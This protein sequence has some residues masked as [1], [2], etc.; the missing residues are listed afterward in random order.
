[1]PVTFDG[2]N[3]KIILPSIADYSIDLDLYSAWKEWVLLSDNA[4]YP[5][6]FDTTGGDP[7]SAVSRIAPYFFIRNDLGWRVQAPE[8]TGEINLDGNLFPRDSL[9]PVFLPPVGAFTVT[10]RQIVSSRATV[11]SGGGGGGGVEDWTATERAQIRKAL[12]IVGS[13][14]TPAGGGQLQDILEKVGRIDTKTKILL[15]ESL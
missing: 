10:F 8:A 4:K 6:A 13:Q 11:E 12:G 3:L 9:L 5:P 15:A 14:A 2:P 1:M 7:I